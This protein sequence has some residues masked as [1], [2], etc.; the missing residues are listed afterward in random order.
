LL[1]ADFSSV[2]QQ[3]RVAGSG[4]DVPTALLHDPLGGWF[5]A[6]TTTSRDLPVTAGVVQNRNRGTQTGW[7]GRF[8][9]NLTPRYLTY[10]GGEFGDGVTALATD[11][12]GNAYVAGT[13][14]SS[15]MPV[16]G[17]A[18]Q[19]VTSLGTREGYFS[20]LNSTGTQ[21][22]YGTYLGGFHTYP[23]NYDALTGAWGIARSTDGR[24]YVGG[25][26]TAASFPVTGNSLRAGMG[27]IADAFLVRFENR[28]LTVT[29]P[30]LLLQAR[31][32]KPYSYQFTAAGGRAPYVWSLTGFKLPD[33]ITLSSGGLLSGTASTA[34]TESRE[35]Q[36]T[37][38]VR[39]ADNA[40]AYK[41]VF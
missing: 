27:G 1:P 14:F 15:D 16:T 39:D 30:S 3:R 26:T 11:G 37:V 5:A 4:V 29:S 34:Q 18:F 21:L 33:G 24:V 38:A 41:S 9:G 40:V 8:D 31:T 23:R 17:D 2:L 6:G 13:T 12:A 25:S 32:E 10:F 20:L 36:F 35:Y 19:D 7:V 22:L 28:A